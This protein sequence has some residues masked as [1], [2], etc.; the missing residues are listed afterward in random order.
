MSD[1]LWH[2]DGTPVWRPSFR[3]L[4]AAAA[5]SAAFWLVVYLLCR[6]VSQ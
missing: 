6:A 3:A 2:H 5:I 1:A 4:F